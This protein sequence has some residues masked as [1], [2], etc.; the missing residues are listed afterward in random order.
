MKEK[1]GLKDYKLVDICLND[2][3]SLFGLKGVVVKECGAY[4]IVFDDTIPWNVLYGMIQKETGCDNEPS[5]CNN[6]N[7]ISFWEIVWNYDCEENYLSM[8]EIIN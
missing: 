3:V 4:G 1:T 2:N 8:V 5:F 7:F 6:D